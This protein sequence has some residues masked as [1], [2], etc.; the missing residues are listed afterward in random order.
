VIIRKCNLFICYGIII[1]GLYII[2]HD[3]QTVHN[4]VL[5][6]TH[7]ALSLKRTIP[8]TNEAYLWHICLDHI[9]SKRIQRLVND[10]FL[11]PI[12]F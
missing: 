6:P 11:G 3:L 12:G 1:D 2:T 4:S 7:N 10:G 8:S 9:N 5:K